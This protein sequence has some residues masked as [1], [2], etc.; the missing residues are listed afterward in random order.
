MNCD[1][2]APFYVWIERVAFG[3]RLER[4]RV[5]F[6]ESAEGARRAL[7]LGDGDGRF[8]TA[9]AVKYPGLAIDCVELSGKMVALAR[10]RLGEG[11]G[12]GV[13][14]VQGDALKAALPCPCLGGG[15]A[16][17]SSYDIVYSHFFLDCFS[18]E[19]VA[20]L[21][22][23]IAE[24]SGPVA[25][26]VISDFREAESG[27]RKVFTAAWIKTMYV[28]FKLATQLEQQQLP[29]HRSALKEHGFQLRE[30]RRSLAGLIV[31]ECWQ[32]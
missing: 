5:A 11:G 1:G 10:K 20:M 18:T 24:V 16:G 29:D 6:L 3:K 14:F 32:R 26:W 31:S 17:L 25:R 28:F 8:V 9:L 15:G 23:R 30:E 12:R 2:I 21:A 27:W 22:R 19:Q 4:H 13:R 7:V